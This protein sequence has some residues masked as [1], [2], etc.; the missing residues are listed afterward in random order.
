MTTF[1]FLAL[2]PIAS[3]AILSGCNATQRP[4]PV[5][6]SSAE[7]Y[8]GTENYSAA[9]VDFREYVERRPD[10]VPMRV[11]LVNALLQLDQPKDARIHAQV[12]NDLRP[13]SDEFAD[14]LART[15][16]EAGER[17]AVVSFCQ[18]RVA[19]RGRVADYIRLGTY[20][21]KLG[22]IDEARIALSTAAR[23]D[24]GRT[25]APQIALAD[26]YKQ[27]NDPTNEAKRLK[28]ALYIDPENKI[29]LKRIEDLGEVAGP[30]AAIRPD[31]LP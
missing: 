13:S 9:A 4:L 23:V 18:K 10:D 26:L 2:I 5:V 17:D 28:M 21:A 1:R 3:L 14:L 12:L 29:V 16:Y 22:N 24:N 19:E 20:S 30:T 15:L 7:Y 6:K 31:E 27:L 11:G 8:V 25:I